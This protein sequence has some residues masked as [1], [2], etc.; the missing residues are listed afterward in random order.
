MNLFNTKQ[1]KGCTYKFKHFMPKM[2]QNSLRAPPGAE[3]HWGRTYK[4]RDDMERKGE[5]EER[6]AGLLIK[7]GREG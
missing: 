6:W 1:S 2:H 3:P 4:E 7:G 5:S